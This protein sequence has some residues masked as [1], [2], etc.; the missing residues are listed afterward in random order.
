MALKTRLGASGW[1]SSTEKC[2]GVKGKNIPPAKINPW[3]YFGV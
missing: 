3:V 1:A 2:T